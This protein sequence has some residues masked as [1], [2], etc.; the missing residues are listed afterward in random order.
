MCYTWRYPSEKREEIDVA[1]ISKLPRIRV[2]NVT[3]GEPFIR[4]DLDEIVSILKNKSKRL[5]ISTNGLLTD[6]IIQLA[7]RNPDIGIRI[8]IEGLLKTNDELRGTKKGFEKGLKTLTGLKYLGLKDVGFGITVSD[9]NAKDL[10]ELYKL[11]KVMDVEFATAVVHNSYYF[12]KF[13][14]EIKDRELVIGQFKALIRELL[15]SSRIKNWYRAYF[16]YGILNYVQGNKRLIPCEMAFSSFYLDPYGELRPCNGMEE[17]MGNLKEKPFTEI[18]NGKEA[19]RIRTLVRNCNRNCW[20]IG[21][22]GEIMKKNV[23]IPTKWI[24]RTKFL[25]QDF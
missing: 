21:S 23:T 2:I 11:A 6:R 18:W 12:H 22:V 1:T 14:N 7:E 13:D 17:T 10:I 5:V 19:E 3:G 15:K 8:S 20:M 25:G 16:N 24:L 9:A 4:E